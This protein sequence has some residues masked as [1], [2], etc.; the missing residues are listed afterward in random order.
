MTGLEHGTVPVGRER[1]DG[2]WLIP[3]GVDGYCQWSLY[4]ERYY[5]L[6]KDY[7]QMREFLSDNQ[8]LQIR[9]WI[10]QRY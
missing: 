6:F 10:P 4:T 8:Y 9:N 5:E 2:Y 7:V 1:D 3:P